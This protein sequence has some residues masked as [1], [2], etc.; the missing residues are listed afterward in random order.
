MQALQ[1][2][3]GWAMVCDM[4][5]CEFEAVLQQDQVSFWSRHQSR[6]DITL[7]ISI[8]HK[9]HQIDESDGAAHAC[10]EALGHRLR[11]IGVHE[12]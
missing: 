4:G 12:G 3:A 11:S 10:I 5:P 7:S 2:V 9:N 1:A 6:P 8:I